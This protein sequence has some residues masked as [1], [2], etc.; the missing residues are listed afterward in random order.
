MGAEEGVDLSNYNDLTDAHAVEG[1]GE[2]FAYSLV[3]DGAS[4]AAS[5]RDAHASHTA[6]LRAAGVAVGPY[7]FCRP[8]ND[9]IAAADAFVAGIGEATDLPPVADV[10]VAGFTRQWLQAWSGRVRSHGYSK[11]GWYTNGN[12]FGGLGAPAPQDIG[13]DLL[14]WAGD[15][16]LNN[17]LLWQYGER[18]IPGLMGQTD[19][20]R[21]LGTDAQWAWFRGTSAPHPILDLLEVLGV[22]ADNRATVRLLYKFLLRRPV[23]AQGYGTFVPY[24]E[25]GG[26]VEG[27]VQ[28]LTD[29]SEG[30]DVTDA[31]RRVLGLTVWPR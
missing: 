7:A 14:W 9:P 22:M 16:P 10:E 27:V 30:K 1:A 15:R 29:S 4:Q 11:L 17:C 5:I 31:E 20:D 2:S 28:A 8:S 21:F 13:F 18:S 6:Q 3:L 24:L 25:N 23:D 12:T 19:V 26:S